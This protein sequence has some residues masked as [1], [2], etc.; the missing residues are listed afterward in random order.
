MI[1]V[2]LG[3]I[4]VGAFVQQSVM[5]FGSVDYE[6]YSNAYPNFMIAVG[7]LL[8]AVHMFGTKVNAFDTG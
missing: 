5:S 3:Y 6:R 7:I 4:F 2:G 1:L 8:I